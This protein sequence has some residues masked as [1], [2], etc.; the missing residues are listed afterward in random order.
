LRSRSGMPW[1]CECC[2]PPVLVAVVAAV[3]ALHC[4]A[5]CAPAAAPAAAPLRLGSMDGT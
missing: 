2:L 4:P 5:S 3:A 1:P